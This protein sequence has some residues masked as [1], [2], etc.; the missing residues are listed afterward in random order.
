MRLETWRENKENKNCRYIAEYLPTCGDCI[1]TEKDMT[2]A[3]SVR[4]I[5]WSTSGAVPVITNY[6]RPPGAA[7]LTGFRPLKKRVLLLCWVGRRQEPE[8]RGNSLKK[9]RSKMSFKNILVWLFFGVWH[10]IGES[11]KRLSSTLYSH[12]SWS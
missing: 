11:N 5:C 12:T 3:V 1:K 2:R 4:G 9:E 8:T 6:P 10:N 7:A